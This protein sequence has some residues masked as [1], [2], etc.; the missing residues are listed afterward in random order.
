M[1]RFRG[2]VGWAAAI[3]PL[4]HATRAARHPSFMASQRTRAPEVQCRFRL[5]AIRSAAQTWHP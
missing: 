2:L 5:V 1:V 4:L 3:A